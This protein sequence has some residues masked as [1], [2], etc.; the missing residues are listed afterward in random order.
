MI[1][2][3]SCKNPHEKKSKPVCVTCN[4]T[5]AMTNWFKKNLSRKSILSSGKIM[6]AKYSEIKMK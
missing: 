6:V 2:M 1:N 3:N 5:F 4:Q